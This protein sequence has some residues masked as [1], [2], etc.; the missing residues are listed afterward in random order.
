MNIWLGDPE[1]YFLGRRSL[2]PA[3]KIFGVRQMEHADLPNIEQLIHPETYEI[4][5]DVD[6]ERILYTR[7]TKSFELKKTILN[8]RLTILELKKIVV[9]FSIQEILI[10]S[11]ASCLSMVQC[12]EKCE[13]ISGI[14]LCNYSNV[15]S[16]APDDWLTWLYTLYK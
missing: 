9:T 6:L 7:S 10:S 12:N 3:S 11:E 1:A 16:V 13:I 15:P 14:C 4:F 2:D 8:L 5:G